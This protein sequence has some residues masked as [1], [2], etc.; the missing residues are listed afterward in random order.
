MENNQGLT[1][2]ALYATD[3]YQRFLFIGL[4]CLMPIKSCFYD[5]FPFILMHQYG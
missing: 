1:L 4:I 2:T 3:P 5:D